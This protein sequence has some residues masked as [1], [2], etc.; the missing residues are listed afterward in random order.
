VDVPAVNG[1]RTYFHLA[2]EKEAWTIT[3]EALQPWIY[4]AV[5]ALA[6]AIE[7]KKQSEGAQRK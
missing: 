4:E 5:P 6:V 2:K 3:T 7:E 1:D